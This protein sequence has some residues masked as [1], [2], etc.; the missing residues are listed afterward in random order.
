MQGCR[1][2]VTT[3]LLGLEEPDSEDEPASTPKA[4]HQQLEVEVPAGESAV[5]TVQ[6]HVRTT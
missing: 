5:V 6:V 3:R 4:S 1:L 2:G